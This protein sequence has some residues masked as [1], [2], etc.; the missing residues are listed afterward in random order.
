M[1]GYFYYNAP[2]DT[3]GNRL[4]GALALPA[5]DTDGRGA[6]SDVV[7]IWRVP[8][9]DIYKIGVTCAR[10]GLRRIRAVNPSAEL[11]VYARVIGRAVDHE[12][13]LLALGADARM[14]G[15]G[16]TEYR[17]LTAAELSAAISYLEEVT[18][19]LD[20]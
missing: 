7:Y 3:G 16:Y 15:D 1:E 5:P 6:I 9:S 17:I 13:A 18:Q 2:P 19:C 14:T 20:H 10:R 11:I 4:A 12:R 8:K